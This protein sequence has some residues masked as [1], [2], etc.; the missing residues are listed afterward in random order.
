MKTGDWKKDRKPSTRLM[1]ELRYRHKDGVFLNEDVYD[2][3]WDVCYTY[4]DPIKDDL[5]VEAVKE[6]QFLQMNAR[7]NISMATSQG[8]LRRVEPGVYEFTLPS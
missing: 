6:D 7:N 3:Y 5:K 4:K 2:A 1:N 8:I